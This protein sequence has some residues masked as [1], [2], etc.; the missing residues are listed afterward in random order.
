MKSLHY[1]EKI[2]TLNLLLMK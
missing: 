2:L 1:G